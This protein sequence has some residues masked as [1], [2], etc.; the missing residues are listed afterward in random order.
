M[1]VEMSQPQSESS[2]EIIR[3]Q[4]NVTIHVLPY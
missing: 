2:G 3:K 4:Y 1:D